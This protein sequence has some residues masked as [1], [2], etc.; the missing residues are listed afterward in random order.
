MDALEAHKMFERGEKDMMRGD[1]SASPGGSHYRTG[2]VEPIELIEAAHLGFHEG[3]AVK[4]LCRWQRKG[5]T[6]DLRKARWYIDRLIAM[7]PERQETFGQPLGEG[8][9]FYR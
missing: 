2:S 3:N 8:G 5:G 7:Q 1:L 4:Y 6:E 9:S